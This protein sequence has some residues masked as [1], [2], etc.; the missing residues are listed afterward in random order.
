MKSKIPMQKIEVVKYIFTVKFGGCRVTL[1][2]MIEVNE[3]IICM[4]V[5]RD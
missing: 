5:V 1:P 2:V 4:Q 3:N